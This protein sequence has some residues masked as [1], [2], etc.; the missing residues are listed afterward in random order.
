MSEKENPNKNRELAE[1]ANANQI[2]GV[3]NNMPLPPVPDPDKK[4]LDRV[5]PPTE[6]KRCREHER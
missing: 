4:P 2:D 3:I 1:E 5:K 6:K